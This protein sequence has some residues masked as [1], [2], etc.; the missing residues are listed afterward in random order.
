MLKTIYMTVA[1]Y[2]EQKKEE[3]I[4]LYRQ[5]KEKDALISRFAIP[6]IGALRISEVTAAD[7]EGMLR[8]MREN[9]RIPLEQQVVK[10]LLRRLFHLAELERLR[11]DNPVDGL[12]PIRIRVK[13]LTWLSGEL[14][15]KLLKAFLW[16]SRPEMYA[17]MMTAGISFP[18]LAGCRIGDFSAQE[19]RLQ[20]SR[21]VTREGETD[22]N[23][24][25][26]TVPLS[27]G[28][29]FLLTRAIARAKYGRTEDCLIFP[30]KGGKVLRRIPVE[31]MRLI[32]QASGLKEMK[33]SDLQ[34]AFGIHAMKE[35]GNPKTLVRYMGWK[36]ES[37]LLRCINAG[38]TT[39]EDD[40]RMDA[41]FRELMEEM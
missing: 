20:L 1:D 31:D 4:A 23:P 6:V 37:G 33:G 15:V 8:R 18:E 11:K 24:R 27:D 17:L 38:I 12:A 29:V 7:L 30:G 39:E 35:G 9:G 5:R 22:R 21:I 2:W 41:C 16:T 36:S 14:E 26:R 25:E 19:K 13:G 32:R 10:T 3:I 34:Y 40:E 28:S